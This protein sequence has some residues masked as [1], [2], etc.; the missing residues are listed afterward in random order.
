MTSVACWLRPG[1][2]SSPTPTMVI[3]VEFA[4][5]TPLGLKLHIHHSITQEG[6]EETLDVPA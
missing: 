6:I 5:A 3:L 4:T 2:P 1:D